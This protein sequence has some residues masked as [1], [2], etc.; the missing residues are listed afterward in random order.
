MSRAVHRT[1]LV[2]DVAGFGDLRRTNLHQVA[3]HNGLY[4]VLT[5][6]F[7]A[8]GI[9]WDTCEDEDRGDGALVLIP[10]SV[11]KSLLVEALPGAL[12][13]SLREHNR[14]HRDEEQIRLRMAL[15]AGEIHYDEHGVVGR[16]VNLTFRLLELPVLKRA[17]ADSGGLLAVVTSAWFYDEVVWH[18]RE[19]DGYHQVRA[20]AKE[21]DTTAWISV[22]GM[23]LSPELLAP[24]AE[25]SA[26]HQLPAGIRQFVGRQSEL[27]R[28]DTISGAAGAVIITAID[29]TAGIGKTTLAM[30]WAHQVKDR[31]PDGQ[32]HV[33]LRGFD[34]GE[35]MDPGQALHGFLQAL[36]VAPGSVPA[37]LETRA[38]LYRSLLA[39]RRMLIVLDNARSADQVRPLLPGTPTCL[40]LVTS[41]NQLRGLMVREGAYRIALDVLPAEDARALLAERID[42]DRLAV[43]P[44]AADELMELC[45]RLPL[46]LSIVAA[47]AASQ[48]NLPLAALVHELKDERH[49]LDALDLGETDLSVRAVF[50]WSYNVL[51]P[52]AARL[53]RL[54]GVHPGPD[55][56]LLACEALAP[57]ARQLLK[58]LVT[59]HLLAEHVPG[60][61]RFHDLLRAYAAELAATEPDRRAAAER[62]LDHYLRAA[63]RADRR[64][65][66]VQPG[67]AE[68]MSWFTAEHD[69]L[70]AMVTFAADNGFAE[71][72]WRLASACQIFL[73]R[74]GR[75]HERVAVTRTALAA[76]READDR[77]GQATALRQ[78]AQGL[79]R[80][81]RFDEAKNLL[82][83]AFEL[84]LALEDESYLFHVHLA[85]CRVFEAQELHQL[86]LDHARAGWDLARR[87]TGRG[88]QAGALTGMGKQESMLGRF[89]E[90][91][92]HSG[93]ALRLYAELPDKEGQANV[94][95][96]IGE[97]DLRLGRTA[98][99]LRH[100]ERSLSL[101]RELGDRYWEAYALDRL[102]EVHLASGDEV[103]AKALWRQAF[104]IFTELRHP[105]AAGVREKLSSRE[106]G[107]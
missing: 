25:E 106:S 69:T 34:A 29:G 24:I 79:S 9:P 107:E 46:A 90:A 89:G 74:A 26:P 20:K 36:D 2:V 77:Y 37:D 105:D 51:S 30:H 70:L 53:F 72:S 31:F 43:E 82:D 19:R 41:R 59:A 67:Y 23:V 66:P 6:A 85:Y 87:R 40:V 94:L 98:D 32:L 91:A 42:G 63:D 97:L 7:A 45:A 58:E 49:R 60:R 73:R 39:E 48:A 4:R 11:P 92:E 96:N 88:D 5:R 14:A 38:A 18:S 103:R 99:A 101:N 3:V 1:I 81:S 56:D 10:P 93:E 21:T 50:S 65:Q 17:L 64:I 76:S 68:A 12:L 100:F 102:G 44:R 80:L 71:Y 15:H 33:N 83:E 52:A 57:D 35:P 84:S 28:L 62:V 55:I 27:G 78:L 75:R 54:L 16:P 61:F 13:D 47:R 22:P 104:A 8:A 86:A 95:K